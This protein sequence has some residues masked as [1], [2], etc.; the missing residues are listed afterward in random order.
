SLI[1]GLGLDHFLIR[2]KEGDSL[3]YARRLDVSLT[4]NLFSVLNN[5]LSIGYIQLSGLRVNAEVDAITGENNLLSMLNRL[6]KK[7]GA[8][9][10]T[11]GGL[12][13][14]LKKL[15]I[16]DVQLSLI[17]HQKQQSLTLSTEDL[18]LFI[19]SLDIKNREFYFNRLEW[20]AP[21]FSLHKYGSTA[22]SKDSVVIITEKEVVVVSQHTSPEM[23]A[24][25]D[26]LQVRQG[27]F[28]SKDET[29]PSR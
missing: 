19:E 10:S 20:T 27:K 25:I 1:S 18:D 9:K 7:P 12:V 26:E 23:I 5:T 3:V 22:A 11:E 29:R 16:N 6:I 17:D 13:L 8:Q 28:A 24:S 2:N 15:N 21:N 4:R 14:D